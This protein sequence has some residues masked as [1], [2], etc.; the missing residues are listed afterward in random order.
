MTDWLYLFFFISWDRTAM[1]FRV[2]VS[3]T[4]SIFFPM[5]FWFAD[6]VLLS[7]RRHSRIIARSCMSGASLVKSLG[8]FPPGSGRDSLIALLRSP[9]GRLLL[10]RFTRGLK[11]WSE[12]SHRTL[13]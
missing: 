9:N 1:I 10:T 7:Y 3:R 5:E 13:C 11:L 2:G 4:L 12:V 6:C 8:K